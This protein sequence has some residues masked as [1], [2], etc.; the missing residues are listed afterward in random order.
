MSGPL[1]ASPALGGEP[2]LARAMDPGRRG[3]P[4]WGGATGI[5]RALCPLRFASRGDT[6]RGDRLSLYF[7]DVLVGGAL[8]LD[9]GPHRGVGEGQLWE[10]A[11]AEAHPYPDAHYRA[12]EGEG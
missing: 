5:A 10:Q 7:L 2:A 8:G 9:A 6:G 3:L 4:R 1:P 12:D 11:A